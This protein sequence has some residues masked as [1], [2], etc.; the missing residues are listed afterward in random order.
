MEIL[1]GKSIE[2]NGSFSVAMF[3]LPEATVKEKLTGN[4]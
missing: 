2:L 3:S 4:R 1:N